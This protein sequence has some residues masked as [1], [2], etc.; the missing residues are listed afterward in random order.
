MA[1][2]QIGAVRIDG[3]RLTHT[4]GTLGV[5]FETD[6]TLGALAQLLDA[7]E[8]PQIEVLGA[9]GAATAIYKNHALTSLTMETIGGKRRVSAAMTATRAELADTETLLAQMQQMQAEWSETKTA[10]AALEGG[11]A[12][13]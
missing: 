4:G 1:S 9:G 12:H 8:A 13:A 11:I 2:I 6:M 3:A 5:S 10:L 7:Q